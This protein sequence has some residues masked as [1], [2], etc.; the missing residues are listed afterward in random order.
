MNYDELLNIIR[1][2]REAGIEAAAKKL[3][4]LQSHEPKWAVKDENS[5]K[6]VGLMLDVCGSAHIYFNNRRSRF[7]RD[8]LRLYKWLE[9][10]GYDREVRIFV[11][12]GKYGG[13]MS[14]FDMTGR[15]E[16]SVN[17]AAHKAAAEVLKK[18]GADVYVGTRID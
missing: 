11:A 3:E 16:I 15:Q 13:W 4:E 12:D 14:I 8:L 5:G 18:H 2:A 1:E 6:L 9:K 7:W 17:E 10:T